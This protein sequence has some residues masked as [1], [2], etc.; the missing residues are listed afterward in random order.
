MNVNEILNSANIPLILLVCGGLC[1]GGVILAFVLNLLGT[2]FGALGSVLAFGTDIITG[3]PVT[4]CGCLVVI[5]LLLLCG[6]GLLLLASV[7]STC[8][9][10]DA[11]NLCSLFGR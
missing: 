8:G 2:I 7:L 9:T 11:V 10:P 3:G 5:V 6:G 1:V 4:W